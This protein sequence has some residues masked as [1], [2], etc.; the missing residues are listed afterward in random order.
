MLD[1]PPVDLELRERQ[2]AQA[3]EGGKAGAEFIDRD[4]DAGGAELGGHLL[5][6]RRLA[7]DLVRHFDDETGPAL[8][9]GPILGD[10]S[11]DRQREQGPH[12]DVDRELQIKAG[13]LEHRPVAQRRQQRLL[14]QFGD[15]FIVDLGLKAAW[16]QHAELRMADARERSGTGRH[17]R[18]RSIL[19]WYQISIQL[20]RSASEG[21]IRGRAKVAAESAVVGA[22]ASS[23]AG[24]QAPRGSLG[25]ASLM[26]AKPVASTRYRPTLLNQS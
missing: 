13:L 6:Q 15:A 12:R 16:R 5:R 19:G 11:R 17:L 1:K 3:G 8:G 7:H 26:S 14:R 10:E 2:V 4:Q 25:S 22:A 23:A 21:A 9:F 18:P 24:A 20:L